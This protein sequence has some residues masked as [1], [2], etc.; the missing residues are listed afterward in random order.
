MTF[1]IGITGTRSGA[2]DEQLVS[3]GHLMGS[4]IARE[5]TVELHHGDCVGVDLQAA[6]FASKMDIHTVCHPPVDESLRANHK[7]D[8]ILPQLNHFARNRNI[9]DASDILIVI[10]YQDEWQPRGGTWYTHDYA[11]KKGVDVATIEQSG[12]IRWQWGCHMAERTA[13][14]TQQA[15]GENGSGDI[16]L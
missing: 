3:L 16:S 8:T 11:V 7:S 9:V 4:V 14:K 15:A 6:I 2:S 12:T 5:P 10:P 13:G 1:K